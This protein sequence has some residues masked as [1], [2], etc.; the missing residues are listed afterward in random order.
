MLRYLF[1]FWI[2]C[3]SFSS[4]LRADASA[5]LNADDNADLNAGVAAYLNLA[6]HDARLAQI[7][8]RLSTANVDYCPIKTPNMGWVLH[9]IAQYPN[10]ENVTKAFQFPAPISVLKT[11]NG[12][13]ADRAGVKDGDGYIGISYERSFNNAMG[14]SR[15]NIS[16]KPYAII[17]RKNHYDRIQM[18][19]QNI[20][21]VLKNIANY[22][23]AVPIVTLIRGGAQIK[24]PVE[25]EM[26]CASEYVLDAR[27]KIDAGANG[28]HVRI[29]LGLSQFFSDD[30]EFAAAVAH[31]LAHNI[32][33]H[34]IMIADGKAGKG[35]L[36]GLGRNK[37]LRRVEEQADRL[38]IWLMANA[39]FDVQAG[40]RMIERL[41][42]RKGRPLFGHITHNKSKKR[43]GFMNQEIEALKNIQPDAQGRRKPPLISMFNIQ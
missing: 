41:S 27:E 36:A 34:R 31:E 13:P 22:D 9:D 15:V 16:S 14:T 37:R 17:E 29:T 4:V 10:D 5:D 30:D 24:M 3:F 2:A 1:L 40:P 42:N 21:T 11:V 28:R 23:D 32:L 18:V 39:G 25:M 7:G 20:D 26:I 8:Y 33:K 12:G 35:Q 19:Q 43:I 38:A 6:E